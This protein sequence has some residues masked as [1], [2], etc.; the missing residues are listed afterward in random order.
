MRFSLFAVVGLLGAVTA[1]P[2]PKPPA[3][4]WDDVVVVMSDG[5]T[6]V[7]K[8]AKYAEIERRAPLPAI[9]KG[10]STNL[11]ADA[12]AAPAGLERRG[13]ASSAEVQ[14]L[15]DQVFLGSDVAISPVVSST[16]AIADV[17]I[18]AGY[19]ISNMVTVTGSMEISLIDIEKIMSM[20]LSLSY[21]KSWTTTETQTL[22]FT[23]QENQYGLVVS[24]PSVRRITGN[25]INGCNDNPTVTPFTSDTYENQSYGNLA[26]VKGVIRL[27]NSTVYPV[28]FCL[29][30][31]S[32]E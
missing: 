20:S 13:C 15:T 11:F 32:H 2:T 3:L 8:A 6:Q 7:M 1:A 31:G 24:Q 14:V 12:D 17:S 18:A 29:G 25:L 4:A 27:C 21:S 28:P 23:M 9:P 16:S 5:T 30:E 22:R 10:H 19:Q 26:W